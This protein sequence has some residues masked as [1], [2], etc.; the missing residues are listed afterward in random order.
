MSVHVK[1]L[2]LRARMDYI[3]KALGGE[4]LDRI[5]DEI[6]PQA[7]AVLREEIMV[8]SWYPLSALLEVAAA[9]ERI[10]GR[11]GAADLFRGMGRNAAQM[12]LQGVHQSFAKENDPG[13]VIKMTPLLWGQYYDSGRAE[14]ESSGTNSAVCRIL[15]FEEPHRAIC[16]G[17]IGWG[18]AAIEIWGGRDARVEER[19]CRVH[20]DA[21]CE[22][23]FFWSDPLPGAEP[24]ARPQSK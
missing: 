17:V 15:E 21:C 22:F 7:R 4:A 10:H 12:A 19:K 13:F 8:S 18:E 23:E 6:S 5:L 9:V 1:G 24:G 11:G 3:A 16:L 2:V 20:G 14:A